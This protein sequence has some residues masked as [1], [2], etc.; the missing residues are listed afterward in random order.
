MDNSHR[1][2]H[3]DTTQFRIMRLERSTTWVR[4]WTEQATITWS[5]VQKLLHRLQPRSTFNKMLASIS[6]PLDSTEVHLDLDVVTRR[7]KYRRNNRWNLSWSLETW[8]C[9]TDRCSSS[10]NKWATTRRIKTLRNSVPNWSRCDTL[11][12]NRQCNLWSSTFS[13]QKM[14]SS[15]ET[16]T[17]ENRRAVTG[18]ILTLA[19][20]LALVAIHVRMTTT[21][22]RLS[23]RRRQVK[24]APVRHHRLYLLQ[25]KETTC[26]RERC[27]SDLTPSRTTRRCLGWHIRGRKYLQLSW[28]MS[29]T[30]HL[31]T[32]TS[33]NSSWVKQTTDN[34]I[35]KRLEFVLSRTQSALIQTIIISLLTKQVFKLS[36]NRTW[37]KV[38]GM[39]VK[40]AG[41]VLTLESSTL[42]DWTSRRMIKMQP[43][44]MD[45]QAMPWRQW[46]RR[47]SKLSQL[48]SLILLLQQKLW[49]L[50]VRLRIN[51]ITHS[52][53]MFKL[54]VSKL[55]P[56]NPIPPNRIG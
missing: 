52:L 14:K 29:D 39:L 4:T 8:A 26:L 48:S 51:N 25:A 24:F 5:L 47:S 38:E 7:S 18:I 2:H 13:I 49:R 17:T 21:I 50:P 30:L 33:T 40:K 42:L 53:W 28:L 27:R 19:H 55:C 35:A 31:Y 44:I 16:I 34:S 56:S 23:S 9:S 6:C 10:S 15:K 32:K 20:T 36:N 45:S 12:S 41:R 54:S 1:S 3:K 46:R 11:I 37:V 43:V 22:G